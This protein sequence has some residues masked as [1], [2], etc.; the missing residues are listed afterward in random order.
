MGACVIYTDEAVEKR[1]VL[2]IITVLSL[3]DTCQKVKVAY[4]VIAIIIQTA[5]ITLS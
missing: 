1:V 4:V 3:S 2:R 5:Q